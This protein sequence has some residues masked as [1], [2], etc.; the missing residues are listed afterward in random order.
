MENPYIEDIRTNAGILKREHTTTTAL[1]I[2]HSIACRSITTNFEND[3]N[4]A[5]ELRLANE[6]LKEV[7]R[8]TEVKQ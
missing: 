1:R 7:E 8:E 2:A 6:A 4:I 5:S 3:G